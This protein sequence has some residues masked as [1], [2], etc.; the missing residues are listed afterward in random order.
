MGELV[1][2]AQQIVDAIRYLTLGTSDRQG[3]PWTSPVYFKAAGL[4]EYYWV[5]TVDAEHSLNLA[6]R[7]QASAVIFDST[8]EPYHGRAVYVSGAAAEVPDDE[9]DRAMD[10][11]PGYA[12]DEVTGAAPYRLYRLTASDLWVLCPREPR[13]PCALHGLA[14]DHRTPL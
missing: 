9:L 4:R 2:H 8:V 12:K 13:Q 5:S 10:V 1:E 11:Y 6:A 14:K 7:P 3:N